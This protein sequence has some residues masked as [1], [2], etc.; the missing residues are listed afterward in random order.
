[1]RLHSPVPIAKRHRKLHITSYWYIPQNRYDLAHR[2]SSY[3]SGNLKSGLTPWDIVF[4][5]VLIGPGVSVS[6]PRYDSHLRLLLDRSRWNIDKKNWYTKYY[7]IHSLFRLLLPISVPRAQTKH[8]HFSTTS[9][10]K[11]G[12]GHFSW[13]L[14]VH[15]CPLLRCQC[16]RGSSREV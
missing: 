6:F 12:Q 8:G 10:R 4:I 11:W 13:V 16:C 15:A 3:R 2:I 1:M 14:G 7:L 9:T 5:D